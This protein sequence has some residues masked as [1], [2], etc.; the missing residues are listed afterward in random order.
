M[1]AKDLTEEELRQLTPRRI[2]F[3]NVIGFQTLLVK[4]IQR[5]L[6][7]YGQ[8][9][10]S[11]VITTV[12]YY[13][14]FSLAFGDLRR[15]ING[16][17]YMLFLMPGLI[18]MSMAQNAFMN[19]SSSFMISK[20]D[21]SIV[22]L[23]MPPLSN[24]ELL[25]AKVLGGVARG[26]VVGIA[27][28]ITFMVIA[29]MGIY[30][31]FYII[32]HAIMGSAFLSTSGFI[33]GIWAEKFDHTAAISNFLVTPMTFLSGTFYSL[34][35]LST[36]WQPMVI[37]NPFFYMIDGFRYGFIGTADSNL[38]AGLIVMVVMNVI[39]FT[40]AYKMLKSGYKIKS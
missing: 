27:S 9:V 5:F 38:M 33:T 29:D 39:V 15:D 30:N 20:Y 24:F 37:Y 25:T 31:V 8:T 36:T 1:I 22:D 4:E 26:L 11:P 23:L 13:L 10:L 40:I 34:D 3:F 14:V 17:S 18:M 32:F 12:L 21:G 16:V 6:K 19:T 35:Q 2:G 7:V 28:A